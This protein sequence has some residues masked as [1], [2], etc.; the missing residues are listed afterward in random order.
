[1]LPNPTSTFLKIKHE[2]KTLVG[3]SFIHFFNHSLDIYF[4]LI[5]VTQSFAHLKKNH[6]AISD[7]KVFLQFKINPDRHENKGTLPF[8]LWQS[9]FYSIERFKP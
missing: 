6:N 1:M 9:F 2:K 3:N 8:L 7:W 5:S 4:N